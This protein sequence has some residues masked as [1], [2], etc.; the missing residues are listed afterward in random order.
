MPRPPKK[1]NIENIPEI[2]YFKPQGVCKNELKEMN[3]TLE[4]IEAIRLKDLEELDQQKCA[5]KMEVSRTTFQRILKSGRKKI[6]EALIKGKAI[7]FKGGNYRLKEGKYRCRNCN[8]EIN[9]NCSP[10][11]HRKRHGKK[12]DTEKCPKCGTKSFK[13]L[14]KKKK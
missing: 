6:A 13:Y 12:N 14:E 10:K 5:D 8:H 11:R 3:L 9:F 1:R 2:K 4:E 7:K